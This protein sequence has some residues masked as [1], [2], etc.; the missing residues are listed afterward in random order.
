M[1][2]GREIPELMVIDADIGK[3][4]GRRLRANVSG[5][6]HINVG[7]AS[8]PRPASRRGSPCAQI[9][10]SPPM[11]SRQHAHARSGAPV[12]LLYTT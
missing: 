9:R 11:R 12:D 6:R 10:S 7:I 4:A 8:F 3:S 2:L 1:E 5:E